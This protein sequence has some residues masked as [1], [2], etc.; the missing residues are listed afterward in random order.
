[1]AR[2]VSLAPFTYKTKDKD[3]SVPF[4][5]AIVA[6]SNVPMRCDPLARA[7]GSRIVFLE[8]EPTDDEVAAFIRHLAAK[9]FMDLNAD[10]CA[11]VAEFIISENCSLGKN[12]TPQGFACRLME[13]VGE[14]FVGQI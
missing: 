3:L 2:R 14:E 11:E 8:H 13:S 1:M 9:G 7:L 6:I 10:E 12:K 5:G 4:S